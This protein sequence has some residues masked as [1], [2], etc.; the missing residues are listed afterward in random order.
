MVKDLTMRELEGRVSLVTGASRGLGRAIALK[1]ASL[2]SKVAINYVSRDEEATKVAD[3]IASKGGEALLVKANI[4]EAKAVREMVQQVTG[5]WGKLDI[6]VNNAGIARDCLLLRM[7]DEIWDEVMNTN[8]RGAY[9][10]TKFALR[11]MTTQG[12]GRIVNISSLAGLVGN[13]GQANYSAAK[14][15]LIAFTRAVAREVG[16]RNITVNAIA[17]G[18]IVTEM[19]DRLPEENKKGILSRIPLQRFG[20]PEDVAELVAFLASDR[21]GYITAQVIGIDGGVL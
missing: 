7:P 5:K 1:L 17:P 4:A 9:L 14:G 20:T 12:W 16:A 21:A 19:T 11:S 8:L 15:G 13:I 18:F 3:E 6:L 10:C 2:G